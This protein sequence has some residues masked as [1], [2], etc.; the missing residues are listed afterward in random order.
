MPSLIRNTLTPASPSSFAP[1]RQSRRL[2]YWPRRRPRARRGGRADGVNLHLF[3][4][5]TGGH[6]LVQTVAIGFLL[7]V[8]GRPVVHPHEERLD[9]DGPRSGGVGQVVEDSP[10]RDGRSGDL[11]VM[12]FGAGVQ[13][14]PDF[15]VVGVQDL[16]APADA[17]AVEHGRVGDQDELD[18]VSSHAGRRT[19][20]QTW[21]TSSKFR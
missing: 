18:V 1:A 20:A 7:G 17:F 15:P 19:S 3:N 6:N 10:E 5:P 13:L 2:L 8:G 14:R 4:P 12:G 21:T 16:Q 11:S 9:D